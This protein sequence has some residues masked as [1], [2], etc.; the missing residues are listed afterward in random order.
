MICFSSKAWT[1]AWQ[2]L[3]N[4][5]TSMI[6]NP[7]A[8]LLIIGNEILSGRTR[9]RNL[10]TLASKLGNIGIKLCEVRV[11]ADDEEAIVAAVNA[12]RIS[13]DYIFT[14]GGIGPTHD[15]ITTASIAKALDRRL[16]RD[17][18]ALAR[19]EAYYPPEKRTCARLK[20][21]DLPE[22]AAL[23]DNPV[24]WAPG[25]NIENIYVLAGV[26]TIMESM[27]EGL[28]PQLKGGPPLLSMSLSC[29]MAEGA[30]ASDLRDLQE[31][32]PMIAIGS[33]PYMREGKYG[34]TIVLSGTN[35][36]LLKKALEDV[37]TIFIQAGGS[38]LSE[39]S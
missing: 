16:I 9:D 28:I 7:S 39:I 1:H 20:M 38:P 19:L 34:T 15:D 30:I 25:F 11:I 29:D 27:L 22:G 33:Y 3:E 23:I 2:L 14:T 17:P 18:R 6:K 21:A 8:C 26:P 36:L 32:Y 12:T 13:F 31:N 35:E 4:N 24:S 10:L 5:Y 37:R